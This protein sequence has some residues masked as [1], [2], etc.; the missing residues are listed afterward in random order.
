MSTEEADLLVAYWD[1]EDRRD[2]Q[3]VSVD[4]MVLIQ[5]TQTIRGRVTRL[6]GTTE[7]VEF[8][9]SFLTSERNIGHI[10][11]PIWRQL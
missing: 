8:P 4:N 1:E 9:V 6:S 2:H 11:H 5:E 3:I 7:T 10:S